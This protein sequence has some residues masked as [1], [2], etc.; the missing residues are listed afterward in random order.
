[1]VRGERLE[2]LTHHFRHN[3]DGFAWGDDGLAST[4][5]ARSLL[6]DAFGHR[7][8]P[9]FPHLCQCT[10]QDPS[11]LDSHKAWVEAIYGDFCDKV[12]AELPQGE[13]WKLTQLAVMDWAFDRLRDGADAAVEV[14]VKVPS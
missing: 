2:V 13:D 5:L 1:M 7:T 3:P 6:L 9:A 14:P 10:E 12:I 4:E 11:D 8:C